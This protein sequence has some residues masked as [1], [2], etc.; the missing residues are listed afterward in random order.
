MWYFLIMHK[1]LFYI[2]PVLVLVNPNAGNFVFMDYGVILVLC[3][4][5]INSVMKL[6]VCVSW[7]QMGKK[8]LLIN[9][10]IQKAE[11]A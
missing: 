10:V 1:I 8:V 9:K 3:T 2:I 4:W 5:Q 11:A 7:T 6:H